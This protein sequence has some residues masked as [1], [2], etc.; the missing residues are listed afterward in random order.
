MTEEAY[1]GG[2]QAAAEAT[3]R[4]GTETVHLAG[5][6][7]HVTSPD[8]DEL[9]VPGILGFGDGPDDSVSRE[10]DVNAVR[11]VDPSHHVAVA[12]QVLGYGRVVGGRQALAG[13]KHK[14]GVLPLTVRN[15]CLFDSMGMD[16]SGPGMHEG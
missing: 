7:P 3:G 6:E 15:G 2:L 4:C 12:R 8:G 10:D 9:A 16:Q 14:H 11:R 1:P 13:G 5:D